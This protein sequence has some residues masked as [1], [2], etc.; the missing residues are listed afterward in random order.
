MLLTTTAE[1]PRQAIMVV[2]VI[3]FPVTGT[4]LL[5]AP[6][7]VDLDKIKIEVPEI[8]LPPPLDFGQPNQ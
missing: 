1:S 6:L 3:A 7:K 4:G 8:E 5:D 2:L